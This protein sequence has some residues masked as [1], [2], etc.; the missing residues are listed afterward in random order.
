VEQ[1]LFPHLYHAHHR[2]HMADLAFWLDLAGRQPGPILELGCGTGRVLIPLAQSGRTVVG[3]DHD[4]GMLALLQANLPP[5][6]QP[7]VRVFLADFTRFRLACSFGLILMP[8]NTYSTLSPDGRQSMLL[9]VRQHL[10]QGGAF[11]AS[12]PNPDW[13]RSLPARSPAE[14]EEV[15]AHPLDGEPVQVS[16][17]WQRSR[18]EFILDWHYDHL[19]PD[20]TVERFT[21][22]QK[23]SLA[24]VAEYLAEL[25]S[26]GFDRVQSFGDFDRS[27]FSTDSPE[28]I[29]L[30]S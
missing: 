29:L 1:A 14:V 21:V 5:A 11:A 17:A 18:R 24:P 8:C 20:G 9:C 2:L 6:L 15:F 13:L 19:K 28:L 27:P 22:Q 23:H 12:L 10:S 4:L 3:L 16:S 7:A 25:N 26:A 30:A